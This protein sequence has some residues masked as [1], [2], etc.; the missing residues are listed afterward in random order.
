MNLM[1]ETF[2]IPSQ[3]SSEDREVLKLALKCLKAR[4]DFSY[5]EIGSFK[6]GS[7]APFLAEDS[8]RQVLSIDDRNRQQP[9][10]RGVL[11]DYGGFSSQDMIDNLTK[12]GLNIDKLRI[13]DGDIENLPPLS[14]SPYPK[15][16]LGFI[17]AEH[18]DTAVFKDFMC[19]QPL[20]EA[21]HTILFHDSTLVA[22]GLEI[23]KTYL[24]CKKVDVTI[25]RNHASEITGFFFGSHRSLAEVIFRDR[26][27]WK[28]FQKRADERRLKSV[29]RNRIK[30]SVEYEILEMSIAKAF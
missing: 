18:T 8:C 20:M 21:D 19:L 16:D 9:D 1:A 30:F 11:F 13:H 6:G 2:G 12:A 14:I 7:L 26:E 29:L 24:R 27:D 22:R 17:D 23:I 4:G 15:F 5:V 3:T 10:E 25:A 28:L